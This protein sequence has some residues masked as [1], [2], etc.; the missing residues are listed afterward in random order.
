MVSQRHAR[1]TGKAR[2]S[3]TSQ[4]R[5]VQI[6][7]ADTVTNAWRT[8]LGRICGNRSRGV[9]VARQRTQE[10]DLGRDRDHGGNQEGQQGDHEELDEILEHKNISQEIGGGKP[11]GELK[12]RR[13]QAAQ[14]GEADQ[15]RA[16]Q[17]L[18]PTWLGQVN[19][20]VAK[21]GRTNGESD[22]QFQD[23]T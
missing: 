20:N 10:D 15:E 14:P 4:Q 17:E 9:G 18:A 22:H 13:D 21:D 19:E 1:G 5:H 23:V 6:R 16:A 8:V 2:S 11:G 12:Q 7:S 3:N